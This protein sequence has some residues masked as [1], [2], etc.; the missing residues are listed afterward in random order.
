[1]TQTLYFN[2]LSCSF[3]WSFLIE[4]PV[5][6]L[7]GTRVP[8][9]WQKQKSV[10][11]PTIRTYGLNSEDAWILAKVWTGQLARAMAR[12]QQ[13]HIKVSKS[14]TSYKYLAITWRILNMF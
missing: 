10:E 6:K 5:K 4:L 2:K 3:K 7:I 11:S 8:S 1:M 9:K 14:S 13:F 12:I